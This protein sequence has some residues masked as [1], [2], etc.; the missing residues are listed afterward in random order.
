MWYKYLNKLTSE[1]CRKLVWIRL[2]FGSWIIFVNFICLQN[3]TRE[4]CS[5]KIDWAVFFFDTN[6]L[7]V[8]STALCSPL[9]DVPW[10][11]I[12]GLSVPALA[13][14]QGSFVQMGF[15]VGHFAKAPPHHHKA[16]VS[17]HFI[18]VWLW[19]IAVVGV[20]DS[21]WAQQMLLSYF[22]SRIWPQYMYE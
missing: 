6:R 7:A 5:C 4:S 18:I 2:S 17:H 9:L 13:Q 14:I 1:L 12:S 21:I 20:T 16:K 19:S 11:D 15:Y 10:L 22:R 8:L 3:Y